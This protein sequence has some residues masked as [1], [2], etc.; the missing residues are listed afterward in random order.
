MDQVIAGFLEAQQA[1][2]DAL[3][4]RSPL[5]DIRMHGAADEASWV[6]DYRCRGLIRRPDGAIVEADHFKVGV[7]MSPDYLRCANPYL[8]VTWLGPRATWHPNLGT[9][10][11][12]D[13]IFICIGHLRPGTPLVDIV[14]Q[15]FEIITYQKATMREDDALNHAAC[16]W[17]RANQHLFPIDRRSLLGRVV[18]PEPTARI[19]EEASA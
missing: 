2:A 13:Q 16:R 9:P 15:V 4:A 6:V 7:R 8:V 5:V 10:P 12:A 3:S 17:A 11:G 14:M 18:F 1:E 19:G